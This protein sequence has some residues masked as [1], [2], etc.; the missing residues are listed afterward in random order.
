MPSVDVKGRGGS[1]TKKAG[2]KLRITQNK[3]GGA[4]ANLRTIHSQQSGGKISISFF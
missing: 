1:V 4:T 3:E 2:R